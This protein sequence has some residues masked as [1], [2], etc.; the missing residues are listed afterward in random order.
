MRMLFKLNHLPVPVYIN[1]NYYYYTDNLERVMNKIM[2]EK[3][4]I[5]RYRMYPRTMAQELKDI[6]RWI[7][8]NI[9]DDYWIN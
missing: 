8:L 6:Q 9:I 5:L 7:G 1:N 2:W 3:E 4:S